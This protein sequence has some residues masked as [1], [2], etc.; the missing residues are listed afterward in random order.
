MRKVVP[1][2]IKLRSIQMLT[3]IRLDQALG[4]GKS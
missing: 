1:K 4:D 2:P 3:A